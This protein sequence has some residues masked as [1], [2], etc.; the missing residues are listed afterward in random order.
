MLGR[1]GWFRRAGRLRSITGAFEPY[2]RFYAAESEK[3][4][5]FA[6][7][8]TKVQDEAAEI[9]RNAGALGG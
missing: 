6:E 5:K 2:Q 3:V 1:V 7:K 8:L 4:E 9:M